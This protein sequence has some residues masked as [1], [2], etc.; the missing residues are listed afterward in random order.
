MQQS[1][2]LLL[3]SLLLKA[4]LANHTVFSD[5]YKVAKNSEMSLKLQVDE[6]NREKL[7]LEAELH[8]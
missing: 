8:R 4:I 7:E 1:T 5:A 6:L 2:A 3:S